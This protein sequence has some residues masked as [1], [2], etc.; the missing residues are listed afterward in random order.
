MWL[1]K[2]GCRGRSEARWGAVV[3]MIDA[4]VEGVG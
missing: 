2:E 4:M 1:H 3:P